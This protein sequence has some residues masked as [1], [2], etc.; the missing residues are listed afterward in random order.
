VNSYLLIGLAV[1]LVLAAGY[2]FYMLRAG[3]ES[4]KRAPVAPSERGVS[5]D[6]R[7][8]RGP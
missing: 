7:V 8:R 2:Y 6:D 3:S 1:W 5:E 4:G